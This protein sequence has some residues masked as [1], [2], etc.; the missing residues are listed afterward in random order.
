[1]ATRIRAGIGGWT[2]APWRDNFYPKGLPQARELAYASEQ[3]SAIEINA[4]FYRGFPRTSFAQW[5]GAVPQGF[6]FS[7]K[8]PRFA[9]QRRELATAA[10]PVERLVSSVTALGPSLG[11]IV[12]QLAPTKQFDAAD[13]SAFLTLLP[14]EADGLK[15]R[16]AIDARHASFATPEFAAL[17][18]KHGVAIVLTEDDE[19][20]PI[21]AVTADFVYLRLRRARSEIKTGY[22]ET[23]LKAWAK[24]AAAWRSGGQPD[25]VEHIG[26]K[27]AR[28][29]RDVF[30]YFINGAK[31]RA[32]AAAQRFLELVG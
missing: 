14:H 17:A 31:E 20:P 30:V 4:T 27:A 24:R 29:A 11:P 10:E 19:V 16:H 6:V 12:W 23:E 1:M 21:A 26:T 9:T 3:L 18:R 15:L 13:M 2:Y 22:P 8:A 25:D 5:A 7:L 28:K 32:P